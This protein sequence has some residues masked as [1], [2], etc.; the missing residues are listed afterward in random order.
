MN[1]NVNI[2]NKNYFLIC[3]QG[4]KYFIGYLKIIFKYV[5]FG[6]EW[7]GRVLEM[8]DFV[9][10]N[11]IGFRQFVLLGFCGYILVGE[12]LGL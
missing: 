3:L 2:S 12:E 6:N 9:F 10:I 11:F 5:E 4:I 1:C 8:F 7:L